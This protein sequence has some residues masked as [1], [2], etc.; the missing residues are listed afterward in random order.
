MGKNRIDK[1]IIIFLCF[2]FCANITKNQHLNCQLYSVDFNIS[3]EDF[4]EFSSIINSFYDS[5]C[6]FDFVLLKIKG[7]NPNGSYILRYNY[8]DEWFYHYKG[9]D[10]NTKTLKVT[11]D[12]TIIKGFESF[13]KIGHFIEICPYS[14]NNDLYVYMIK[15]NGEIYAKYQSKH[16]LTSEKI[17]INELKRLVDKLQEMEGKIYPDR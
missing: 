16:P 5:Q 12:S 6:A 11:A 8:E 17:N 4:P 10:D 2:I 13:N 14:S 15:K 3:S 7:G 1:F 9:A